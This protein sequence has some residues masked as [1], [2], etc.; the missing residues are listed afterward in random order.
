MNQACTI[1]TKQ[2]FTDK[3]TLP[4]KLM[5]PPC[6]CRLGCYNKVPEETR[7]RL[8]ENF[9]NNCNQTQ[10]K[11]YIALSITESPKSR[12][13]CRGPIR[14]ERRQLTCT[15]LLLVNGELVKVCKG[16]FLNTFS[17]SEKFMRLVMNKKRSSTNGIAG[18]DFKKKHQKKS[19]A[20]KEMIREHI[21]SFPAEILPEDKTGR[22]YLDASLNVSAMHKLYVKHCQEKG[23][24]KKDIVRQ[25]YYREIFKSEF[26]LGFKCKEAT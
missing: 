3:E 8:Y 22:G 14:T 18:M 19:D 9:W 1:F 11:Q 20:T 17:V 25:G 4:R 15:Y 12:S 6:K 7:K 2:L 16:M 26:N 21:R 24:P 5:G 23:L 13:R 10:R